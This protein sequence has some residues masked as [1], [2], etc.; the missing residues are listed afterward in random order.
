MA[1]KSPSL[2]TGHGRSQASRVTY[3][4]F[5]RATPGPEEVISIHYDTYGNLVAMGVIRG[6]RIA[7]PFPGQ[8]VPDPR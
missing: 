1:R 7:S 5:E 4:S 8:F 6:P 2:G 3:A